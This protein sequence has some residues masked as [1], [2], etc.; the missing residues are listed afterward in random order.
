MTETYSPVAVI[1]GFL[2]V[3][4]AILV[5]ALTMISGLLRTK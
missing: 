5:L 1:K 3:V 2:T 4:G